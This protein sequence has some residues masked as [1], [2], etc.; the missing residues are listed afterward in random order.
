LA[1]N[2]EGGVENQGVVKA[3]EHP[4]VPSNDIYQDVLAFFQQEFA[5]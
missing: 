3:E 5:S 2:G 4:H 1:N